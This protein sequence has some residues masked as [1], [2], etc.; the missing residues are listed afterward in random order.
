MS[1]VIGLFK[2]RESGKDEFTRLVRAHVDIMF[3]MAWRWTQ[4]TEDAEDLVQ[5]VLIKLAGKVEE[6]RGV[7]NLRPWLIKVLYHRYVDLYRREKTSP[8]VEV[9]GDDDGAEYDGPRVPVS[10]T[11]NFIERLHLQDVLRKAINGL[12]PG[13]RDVILLH[14]VEGYSAFEVAEILD[15][16]AG[17]VKS[18]LHRARKRL[19]KVIPVGTFPVIHSC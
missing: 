13:Q 14:D 5:D 8:F 6:M 4:C 15:I 9:I 7:D 3:R 17:T 10:E 16:S 11:S 12:E 2:S 18:R 19:Q 1:K